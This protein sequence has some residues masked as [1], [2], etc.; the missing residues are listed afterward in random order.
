[1]LVTPPDGN[2][3]HWHTIRGTRALL[4]ALVEPDGEGSCLKMTLKF[5]VTGYGIAWVSEMIGRGLVARNLEAIAE[6]IRH[7]LEF[8]R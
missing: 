5:S 4:D 6:E 7:H 8:E 2:R 3:L 1:M